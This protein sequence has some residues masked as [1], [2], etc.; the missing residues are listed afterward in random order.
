MATL[1]FIMPQELKEGFCKRKEKQN[2]NKHAWVPSGQSRALPGGQVA[3]ECYCKH[4]GERE[5]GTVTRTEFAM[6]SEYWTEL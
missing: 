4:C 1:N 2:K 5:W 3:I 6:I